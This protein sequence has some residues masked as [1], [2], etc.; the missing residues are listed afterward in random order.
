[1]K[2]KPAGKQAKS[3]KAP[4]TAPKPAKATKQ[5]KPAPR[6]AKSA[7][8]REE[9]IIP[10]TEKC[11]RCN[12]QGCIPVLCPKCFGKPSLTHQNCKKCKG[13]GFIDATCKVCNGSGEAPDETE[14]E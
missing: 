6:P 9:I 12:G 7:A 10:T 4:K 8:K 2:S 11:D 1:M 3:A 5:T 13:I 14:A